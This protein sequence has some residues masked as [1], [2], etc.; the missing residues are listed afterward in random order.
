MSTT[1]SSV[2]SSTSL[3]T[4]I[5]SDCFFINCR[6]IGQSKQPPVCRE[7]SENGIKKKRRNS[8]LVNCRLNKKNVFGKLLLVCVSVCPPI[9]LLSANLS[10]CLYAYVYAC[11][12]VCPPICLSVCSPISLSVCSPICLSVRLHLSVCP[13]I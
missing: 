9:C 5:I 4:R 1:V 13:P 7:E 10:V 2:C 11:L 8:R 12:C 6:I 3:C